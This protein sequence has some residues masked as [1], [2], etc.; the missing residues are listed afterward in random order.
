MRNKLA[1]DVG[2]RRKFMATF[3]RIGKKIN[4]LGHSE[5]TILLNAIT[6]ME[7]NEMVTDHLW[8]P[9]SRGFQKLSLSK[10]KVIVFE[11]RIK[12]YS[13][14]YVNKKY[15]IANKRTDYKLSHPTKIK[16]VEPS[17]E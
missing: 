6:D 14:G 11:A 3:N 16:H 4:F 1:A 7:T 10:G 12:A 15:G 8:F 17:Q 9:Y 2:Q 13:K 5:E